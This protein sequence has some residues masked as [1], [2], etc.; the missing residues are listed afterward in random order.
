MKRNIQLLL[1]FL[2][3]LIAPAAKANIDK[4]TDYTVSVQSVSAPTSSVG[5]SS[6]WT[7]VPVYG[8]DVDL[9]GRQRA[10]FAEFD[11]TGTVRVRITN[12]RSDAIQNGKMQVAVRPTSKGIRCTTVDD[13][14]VELELQRPE[15]LSVEFN[16]DRLHNLHLFA[17]PQL[18]ETY[19]GDGDKTI[20]WKGENAQDVFVKDARLIY[21]GPGVHQPK[22]LPGRDIR[23]P[24]NCTVYLA[25]GAVVRARLVVDHARNVR[26][27]GRGMLDHPLRGIEIT[28]SHNVLVDGITVVNPEHYTVFGGQS[29]SI[30]LRNLK[31]FSC[32]S[33]TDGIDLMCCSN[34][35][36]QNVFLRTSDDCIA[37]YN[38]RW[39]YWGGARNFNISGATLWA[40][41]A[42]AVN[43][44][45][46][47]DDRS[48][49]GETLEGVH[50]SDC[51]VLYAR[52]DAAL[53]LS[54][55]D[56][57]TLR[58][59]HFDNIRMDDLDSTSLIG[60]SVV[61][62]EKY[63]RAPGNRITDVS[64]SNISYTGDAA[65]LH[66]CFFRAYDAQHTIDNVQLRNI[67]INGKRMG[68]KGLNI[69]PFVDGVKLSDK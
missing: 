69:G 5:S 9:K 49:T 63:N 44:G 30:T 25:P 10:S 18:T 50:I 6:S 68:K 4:S 60:L 13:R 42:H 31:T 45:T 21:F 52:T 47:G 15:Y 35:T 2:L 33:W 54:C 38:H 29:D 40:D 56:K 22:D 64:F 55:G 14:T 58:D 8:C 27:V 32:R 37:L 34:V 11:M 57:N 16:G 66:P 7:S 51:D 41:V 28:F 67:R 1:C 3:L 36:I 48:T 59:I 26:I 39:W 17:N 46:H 24:S 19:T 62:S 65:R 12:N 61:F 43:I 53:A 20:N 23:I